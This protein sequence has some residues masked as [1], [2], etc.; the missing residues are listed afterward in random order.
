MMKYLFYECHF[1]RSEHTLYDLNLALEALHKGS[2]PT[3]ATNGQMIPLL[4]PMV[5]WSHCCHQRS[6]DPTAVT[7]GQMIPLLPPMVKWSHWCHQWSNDPTA[8]TNGQMVAAVGFE[9]KVIC[10][11]P[12]NTKFVFT[13]SIIVSIG[14]GL[15][16]VTKHKLLIKHAVNIVV[17]NP[18]FFQ[19][20]FAED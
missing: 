8:A 7:N 4:P 11:T 2:D 14:G 15:V 17:L 18:P 16:P 20:K 1:T 10:R 13:H 3:A 12:L 19:I 5:K 6:N 9:P